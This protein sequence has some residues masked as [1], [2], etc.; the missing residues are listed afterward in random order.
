MAGECWTWSCQAG[1]KEEGQKMRYMDVINEYMKVV[2]VNA[3]EAEDGDR[4]REVIRC[5]DP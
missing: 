3:E 4:W 5:G 2:G 1:G